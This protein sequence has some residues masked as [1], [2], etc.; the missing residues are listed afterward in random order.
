MKIKQFVM[1]AFLLC[2]VSIASA[3]EMIGTYILE[4]FTHETTQVFTDKEIPF[5]KDKK[6]VTVAG[7]IAAAQTLSTKKADLIVLKKEKYLAVDHLGETVYVNV[8]N[9]AFK[10]ITTKETT[11][12]FR[13][14]AFYLA[15]EYNNALMYVTAIPKQAGRE[16]DAYS[17]PLKTDEGAIAIEVMG[18]KGVKGVLN[19]IK[20]DYQGEY[21][22]AE[23]GM[24]WLSYTTSEGVMHMADLIGWADMDYIV[25]NFI[26]PNDKGGKAGKIIYELEEGVLNIRM[27]GRD[28]Y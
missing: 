1:L 21:C 8:K 5:Y 10:K 22:G 9:I 11:F 26:F 24:S 2:T 23:N 6:M 18:N 3:Q 13:F 27:E 17:F 14:G 16:T 4:P 25:E 19:F 15:G 7:K 12:Y 28:D 20:V